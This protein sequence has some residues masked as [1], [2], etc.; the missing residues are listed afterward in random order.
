[1]QQQI[2]PKDRKKTF[3]LM[4]FIS[5]TEVETAKTTKALKMFVIFIYSEK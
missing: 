4:Y 1:M 2:N 5:G 3:S